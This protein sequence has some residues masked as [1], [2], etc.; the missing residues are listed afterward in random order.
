M[1]MTEFVLE[2]IIRTPIQCL[3]FFVDICEN[4]VN[5]LFMLFAMYVYI[6]N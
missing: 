1:I 2:N 3:K 5:R 6:F 4:F